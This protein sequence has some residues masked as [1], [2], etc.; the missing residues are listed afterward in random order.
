MHVTGFV[1]SS[2]DCCS[3]SVELKVD[4][5]E[6]SDPGAVALVESRVRDFLKAIRAGFFFPGTLRGPETDVVR[7]SASSLKWQLEVVNLPTTAFAVL[8]G[9][10]TDCRYQDV[11]I[12]S[13]S[14][15]QVA[16]VRRR[17]RKRA[18]RRIFP[19]G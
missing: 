15:R 16:V 7:V 4:L 3:G 1:A 17:Q 8:G 14:A 10:L 9:V 12:R 6:A 18:P 2:S 5:D 11:V 13:A 19:M